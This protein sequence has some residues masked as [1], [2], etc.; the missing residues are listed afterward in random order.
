MKLPRWFHR[1]GS[2][3]YVF[4]LADGLAPWLGGFGL[5]L[6]VVGGIWGLVFAPPD[7]TQGEVYRI[8]YIH[9]PSAYIGMMAY[10][11]M[12]VA[13]GIGFI[14]R[15]KLAHAAAVSAAPVGASFTFC[16][17]VTGAVWGR[18]TWGT[19]WEWG[20]PR[21]MFE[22]LLLF[23][24]LGYL[25]LRAAYDDRDK[26]DRVS[27]VLA[28]VGVVNV[29]IIHFSVEWWNSLHQGATISRLDGPTIDTTMLIPLLLMIAAFTL[30]FFWL[31]LRRLQAEVVERERGARWL[32]SL[33]AEGSA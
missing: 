6:L 5:G 15:I 8:I 3:P 27:A 33:L 29:P 32:T 13:G 14:W 18:P 7:V 1:F 25:A 26:A 20:D 30:I 12:A 11:L 24:F 28:V 10:T 22:L 9:V 21:I 4:G 2:P 23:L 16:A 19:Y 17:L 31:L